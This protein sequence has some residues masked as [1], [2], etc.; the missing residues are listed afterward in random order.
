MRKSGRDVQMH[1]TIL[2][3]RHINSFPSAVQDVMRKSFVYS[4][5][6]YLVSCVAA[7]Q[8]SVS[9]E[10]GKERERDRERDA[11]LKAAIH[12]ISVILN[13][14]VALECASHY[15]AKTYH[16]IPF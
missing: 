3:E 6:L 10:R 13:W 16:N 12:T 14:T 8:K 11:E 2:I 7:A 1:V 9:G 5:C 15:D 4:P